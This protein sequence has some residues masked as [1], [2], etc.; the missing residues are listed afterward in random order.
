MTLRP[1]IP[2]PIQTQVLVASRRRCCLCYFFSGMTNV[3]KG[4]IAHLDGSPRNYKFANLVYLC[5]V[6]HDD[7]DSSTR[8][9]KGLT[10]E[11]VRHYRNRLYKALKTKD[12]PAPRVNG[13]IKLFEEEEWKEPLAG[14]QFLREPWHFKIFEEGS[15]QL[16]AYK[17][18]NGFD[19]VCRIERVD[20]NDGRVVVI[21]E[22][23]DDNPGM[24]I[25][26]AIE[27]VALQLCDQFRIEPEQLVLIEH[28]DTWFAREREWNL[29]EFQQ[30]SMMEGFKEPSWHPLSSADWAILGM[31]PR[32]RRKRTGQPESLLIRTRPIL[33]R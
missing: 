12:T 4:Q 22:E 3:T 23:V 28:Y 33:R 18:P 7:F 14:K 21:C 9:S 24:S 29:V 31:K 32:L 15:P 30:R 17:S 2:R 19:G 25:T 26:N 1:I 6:H 10:I 20:L 13:S 5:L 27:Y 8:Q 11:E 16:F